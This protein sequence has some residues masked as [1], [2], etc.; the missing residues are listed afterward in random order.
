MEII[1]NNCPAQP[2]EEPLPLPTP[3]LPGESCPEGGE[4]MNQEC[5]TPPLAMVYSEKQIWGPLYSVEEG[6]ERGTIFPCL[7]KPF[8]GRGTM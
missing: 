5:Q 7:D 4:E 2:G 3:E 6:L 1:C 8:M